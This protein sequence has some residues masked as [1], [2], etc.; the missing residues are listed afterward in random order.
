MKNKDREKVQKAC[1]N[2][3]VT[4]RKIENLLEP[5]GYKKDEGLTTRKW[6]NSE[7]LLSISDFDKEFLSRI[8]KIYHW[9]VRGPSGSLLVFEA[10]PEQVVTGWRV[11]DGAGD[12]I[13]KGNYF[14]SLKWEDGEPLHIDDYVK[15]G[16]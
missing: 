10:K 5:L 1:V 3:A 7:Y 12:Y 15:R 13:P 8:D 9:I 4:G 2:S 6:L 11:A 16:K 14:K